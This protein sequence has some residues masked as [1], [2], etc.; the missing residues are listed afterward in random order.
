MDDIGLATFAPLFGMSHVGELEGLQHQVAVF[1]G[2]VGR[3]LF[4]F[5]EIG[6]VILLIGHQMQMF[7][8]H[9]P[10]LARASRLRMTD[11]LISALPS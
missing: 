7:T 11:P 1:F 10:S 6:L 2:H 8:H 4:H 9:K 5:A 3:G